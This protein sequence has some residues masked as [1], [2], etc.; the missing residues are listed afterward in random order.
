MGCTVVEMLTTMS[1]H[2]EISEDWD[3]SKFIFQAG[4]GNLKYV[5]NE[6]CPDASAN[7]H[8]LLDKIFKPVDQ[9]ITSEQLLAEINRL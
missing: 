5:G 9:R 1:P 2:E 4:Q 7:I 3:T 8:A 6:L